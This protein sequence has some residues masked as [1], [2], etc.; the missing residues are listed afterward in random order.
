MENFHSKKVRYK[1]VASVQ[2][3]ECYEENESMGFE[4]P[5]SCCLLF[6]SYKDYQTIGLLCG[7]SRSSYNKITSP[8]RLSP[9]CVY[10]EP[11]PNEIFTAISPYSSRSSGPN[12]PLV[13]LG[14]NHGIIRLVS[15]R[16]YQSEAVEHEIVL[17]GH[18]RAITSLQCVDRT[19]RLLVSHSIDLSSRIWD[20]E[21]QECLCL[22][23]HHYE[24]SL[25]GVSI[26][27]LIC[28][29]VSYLL[30]DTDVRRGKC[31]ISFLKN[32][33]LNSDFS[34]L[35]TE[36]GLKFYPLYSLRSF[37]YFS[38]H[39]LLNE[40]DNPAELIDV[41]NNES[42]GI[43]EQLNAECVTVSNVSD[44]F[45]ESLELGYSNLNGVEMPKKIV[46]GTAEGDLFVLEK[47]K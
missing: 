18:G 12:A 11:S 15:H 42:F 14:T 41:P 28:K 40:Y 3:R 4:V 16:R 47:E 44:V 21:K 45:A 9:I 1:R 36:Q 39:S 29:R 31:L 33:P 25:T 26:S 2:R 46:C 30:D 32:L 19:G 43:V 20:L 27:H 23:N 5:N 22:I 34:P 38:S 35:A 13:L 7:E 37:L 8:V 17:K 6:P 10:I 24:Q